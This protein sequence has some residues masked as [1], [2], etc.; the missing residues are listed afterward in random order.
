MKQSFTFCTDS[1][2]R[3]NAWG[4][5]ISELTGRRADAV[6]GKKYYDVLPR[7][8]NGNKEAVSMA[9]KN[10][11]KVILKG[12]NFN[13]L[14]GQVKADIVINPEKSKHG[15]AE[16][17]KV[18]I[19]PDSV[20]SVVKELQ[21]SQWLID[22][23]KVAST[24]AH[25]VRSPLN[26]IKGAVVYLGDKYANE[27][28]L[29]EFTK[30]M[31]D[32]ISRLDSFISKFL[33]TSVSNAGLSKT[34]INSLL[35]KIELLTSL[36]AH[37]FKI[38]CAYE[39]GDIPVI[40]ADP[41]EIEQAMLN[42]INNALEAMRSGGQ[43]TVKTLSKKHSGNDYVVIEISDTGPGMTKNR[44]GNVSAPL[45][46]KGKGV[47]L[48]ITREILKTYGGHLEIRNNKVC[49]TTV[50]LSIPLNKTGAKKHG[51]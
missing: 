10:N 41:F 42:I 4:K 51:D 7:I 16:R 38:K 50:K 40:V 22:I 37:A 45:K 2:L 35:K 6:L 3:I 12:Y 5:K 14:S 39:Y 33:S 25:G 31:E 19:Y 1:Q 44:I 23:G 18:A 36:N 15:K 34:D 29:V 20:C 8:F 30:I 32:E 28:T 11:T 48:F 17:V 47:G 13:C 46:C 43:L 24:L 21:N 26:S 27:P 49:G 9:F